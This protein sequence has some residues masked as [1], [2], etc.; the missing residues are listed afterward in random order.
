MFRNLVR[1]ARRITASTLI[2]VL[3]LAV[4]GQVRA[5]SEPL[6]PNIQ[7]APVT[8]S[9][10]PI[11][12]LGEPE[13][14]EAALRAYLA[15]N[16]VTETPTQMMPEQS[17]RVERTA[18]SLAFIPLIQHDI[19][20]S[21]EPP[22]AEPPSPTPADVAVTIWPTPSIWVARGALL[23]YEIRLA[24]HGRGMAHET[25]V[26]FPINRAQVSDFS[27]SLN[28]R[29]GDWVRAL[30][31]SSITVVFGPLGAGA[32]RSGKLF[33]RVNPTLPHQTLI[34]VRARYTFRGDER[35]GTYRTNW[36]PVLVGSGP[37]DAPYIWV[38]VIPERGTVGTRFAFFTNR[39][40]PGE[41]VST[42]LNAP[43]GVQ[44]L[45]LRGT[46]NI[47]G[48]VEVVLDS[49]NLAK[50]TYQ[51]VLYGQRSGLTGV[52]SFSVQ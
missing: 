23:E 49:A 12:M 21:V 18:I 36:A 6:L 35:S 27:T 25:V 40:L 28:S 32:T 15:D 9:E 37:S 46:A 42:W 48:S 17:P 16:P 7:P 41:G 5:Q 13:A 2:I 11:W 31:Q 34:D 24:N 47:E 33:M 30:D 4:I 19:Q 3:V 26:L 45:A 10:Q 50:G 39:F 52:A 1:M 38:R 29:A 14:V 8:S 51:I 44:P 43:R 22:T 20:P